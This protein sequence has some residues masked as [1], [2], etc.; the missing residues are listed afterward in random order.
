V[1]VSKPPNSSRNSNGDA[2]NGCPLPL[3]TAP[4]ELTATI[5][6]TVMPLSK[7]READP[8]PPFKF[9]VVAPVPA[10]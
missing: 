8:K 3:L 1:S 9:A 7:I 6:A 10:P 5:A 2:K 4:K